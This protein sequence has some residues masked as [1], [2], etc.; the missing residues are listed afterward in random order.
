MELNVE[1]KNDEPRCC[2][3][4]LQSFEPSCDGKIL[5][6][7]GV[8]NNDVYNISSPFEIGGK[9]VIAGRVEQR[10]DYANSVMVFF[11]ESDNSWHPVLEAPVLKLE[12]PFTTKIGDE[13]ILG[14]VEVYTEGNSF[15][16]PEIFYKTV[17][18]RGKDFRSLE[19]FA[20]GPEKMKDIRLVQHTNGKI[21]VFTR[22][23][24]GDYGKGM[25]GFTQINNL[26][27]LN[28][29]NLLNAEILEGFFHPD[30]WGGANELHLLPDGRLGVLGHIAYED[31][32]EGKHYYSI[33]FEY[34]LDTH[35][36]SGMKIVVTRD[37]FTPGEVK[38]RK[39]AD[40]VFSGGLIRHNN[41]YATWFGGLSDAQAG[42]KLVVDPF[43]LNFC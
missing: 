32:Y 39:Y 17:F 22:P 21:C 4:L 29:R 3:D 36:A 40:I 28:C 43:A 38:N 8:G 13:T 25:M 9:T 15:G 5:E 24:G 30:E 31:A 11:E 23:Q 34:D 2:E 10:N 7:S 6:F 41:G 12:D 27:E 1:L 35:K 16:D 18:Y 20:E 42:R 37:C 14:G 26:E 33:A 19:K